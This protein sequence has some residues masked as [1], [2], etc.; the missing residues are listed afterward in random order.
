MWTGFVVSEG[1]SPVSNV[2]PDGIN[3]LRYSFDKEYKLGKVYIWNGNQGG[4]THRGLRDIA[5][6]YNNGTDWVK[7]DD[8]I[9]PRAPGTADMSYNL[10]VDF[11]GISANEVVILAK[12]TN[13]NWGDEAS[14]GFSAIR[15]GLFDE[16]A[17]DTDNYVTYG[18]GWTYM[19]E[20]I[21]GDYND[22]V[23]YATENGSFFEYTFT[24]NSVSVIGP[25]NYDYGDIDIY[26]N[27]VYQTTVS[28]YSATYQAE[29]VLYSVTGLPYGKHVLKGVKTSGEYIC[30]DKFIVY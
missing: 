22:D 23:H 2:I 13:G 19:D 10:L 25:K 9:V 5:I 17:N 4:Y 15:F 7:L 8:Y 11:N 20:R 12:M 3:W 29:Q 28:C 30:T 18:V 24:G 26:L 1:T 21:S 14:I 6:Y 27:G 16:I